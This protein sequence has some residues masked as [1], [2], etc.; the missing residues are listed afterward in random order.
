MRKIFFIVC[1]FSF[2]SGYA[3]QEYTSSGKPAQA[4][5]KTKS[6]KGK[7]FDFSSIVFGGGLGLG[8][9]SLTSSF[10][11]SPIVGY[12]FLVNLAACVDLG[13]QYYRYKDYFQIKAAH[14]YTNLYDLKSSIT[15]AGIWVRYVAFVELLVHASF[16]Y[17]F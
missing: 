3:Q 10:S 1:F 15:A 16:V 6:G 11:I 4:K 9:V 7:G 14:G 12:R 13:Y 17:D 8:F 5:K 2:L